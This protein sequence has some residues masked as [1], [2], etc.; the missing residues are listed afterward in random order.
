MYDIV[1]SQ[2][3]VRVVE[4]HWGRNAEAWI[5]STVVA[6]VP[7]ASGAAAGALPTTA[8]ARWGAGE[9]GSAWASPTRAT[10]EPAAT[11]SAGTTPLTLCIG[12]LPLSSNTEHPRDSR[13]F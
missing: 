4:P 7:Y 8:V 5:L 3:A 12:F 2:Y 9:T 1:V 10:S 13:D 6:D 11:T